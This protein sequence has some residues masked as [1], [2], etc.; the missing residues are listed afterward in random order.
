MS[1]VLWAECEN[2]EIINNQSSKV[3]F[4]GKP[5]PSRRHVKNLS[6][7]PKPGL[8]THLSFVSSVP[9]LWTDNENQW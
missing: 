7:Q 2:S 8:S 5:S 4:F 3:V 6:L 1:D 9:V